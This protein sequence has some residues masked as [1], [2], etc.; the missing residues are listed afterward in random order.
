MTHQGHRQRLR[1][2][3]CEQGAEALHEHQLLELL[4]T[5]A[6]P[7]A[8]VNPLAHALLGRYGSLGAVL[9]ADPADLVR[10]EG[11]GERTAT[12][13]SL[14]GALA[15]QNTRTARERPRLNTPEEA[16]RYCAALLAGER[17]ETTRA[18]SL[19]KGRRVLHVDTVS[20]GT[21]SENVIY[22]RLVAEC[23]LRH[24]ANSVIL[25]HNHP[26]GEPSPSVEDVKAT[27]LV[28]DA[29]S[30]IG[31]T[32]HDHIIVGGGEAYSMVRNALLPLGERKEPVALAAEGEK[33]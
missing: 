6:I 13:L 23:A 7:R 1:E 25:C 14:C 18:I 2:T 11:V 33:K 20:A 21:L 28:C 19:D 24:G 27:R 9:E 12:L 4:L 17:Y 22:P 10:V 5:F 30:G 26:S 8:D 32:L 16:A 15:R 3:F 31:I 29:L